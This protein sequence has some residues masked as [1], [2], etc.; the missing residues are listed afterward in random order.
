[1]AEDSF[2]LGSVLASVP[3]DAKGFPMPDGGTPTGWYGLY[4][5][6]STYVPTVYVYAIC[7]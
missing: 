5:N 2:L 4:A 7:Q 1:M 3:V 6:E